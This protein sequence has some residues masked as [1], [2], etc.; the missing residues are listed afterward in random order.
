MKKLFQCKP[1]AIL[2]CTVLYK[3]N[4][5]C[6][7]ACTCFFLQPLILHYLPTVCLCSHNL[8]EGQFQ[9]GREETDRQAVRDAVRKTDRQAG[10]KKRGRSQTDKSLLHTNVKDNAPFDFTQHCPLE[11][12][13]WIPIM[14][15]LLIVMTNVLCTIKSS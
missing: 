9:K 4:R 12:Y 15:S 1:S 13:Q 6:L 8:N 3:S 5:A 10:R 14:N 7:H 2:C 11:D